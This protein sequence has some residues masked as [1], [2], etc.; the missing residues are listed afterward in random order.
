IY[1]PQAVGLFVGQAL[2][3]TVEKTYYMARYLALL[4]SLVILLT[5]FSVY[6]PNAF[7]VAILFMPL[8]IFQ[9]VST[10]QDGFAV[11][12]IVLTVSLYLKITTDAKNYKL[13]H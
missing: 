6:R 8:A 12:L 2:N 9:L 7:V 3:L 10:S 1:F 4:S 13:S 5:A 11:A